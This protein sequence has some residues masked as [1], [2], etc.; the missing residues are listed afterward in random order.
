MKQSFPEPPSPHHRSRFYTEHP[1]A[2]NTGCSD[3]RRPA[4]SEQPVHACPIRQSSSFYP[5]RQTR[6]WTSGQNDFRRK[7]ALPTINHPAKKSPRISPNPGSDAS[8][9]SRVKRP[10]TFKGSLQL[11]TGRGPSPIRQESSESSP[12]SDLGTRKKMY[13]TA[14][15]R[16]KTFLFP[17]ENWTPRILFR[18][19]GATGKTRATPSVRTT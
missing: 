17:P 18:P 15:L 6:A 4:A 16:R 9:P 8:I 11:P 19:P 2:S 14:S 3:T 13:A 12:E 5:I 7:F 10:R 1:E